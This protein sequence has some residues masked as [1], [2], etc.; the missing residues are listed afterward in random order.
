MSVEFKPATKKQL[1]ALYCIYKKDY[2]NDNLSLDEAY[3]LI[4]DA[5]QSNYKTT[6][7]IKTKTIVKKNNAKLKKVKVKINNNEIDYVKIYNEA[8]EYAFKTIENFKPTPMV[9]QQRYS[10]LDDNSPVK[11][12][13]YIESGVCGFA[14]AN[15]KSTT[16]ENRQFIK[17]LKDNGILENEFIKGGRPGYTIYSKARTQSYETNIKWINAFESYLEKFNIKIQTESRL[18]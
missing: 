6:I 12:S 1:Y 14:F 7:K 16:K 13:W 3:K 9:V 8:K 4:K 10:P 5:K 15:I 18:D 17:Q 2:R 11:Q